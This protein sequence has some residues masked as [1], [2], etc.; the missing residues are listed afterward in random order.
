MKRLLIYFF[1]DK[2]G[3]V[4]DYIPYFLRAAQGLCQEVC[5]VVNGLLSDEGRAKV[6]PLTTKILI[7]ENKGLDAAAY[8]AAIFEYGFEKLA[9]YDEVICT[10][11]TFFGPFYPLEEMFGAMR[12]RKC[13][14]WTM[15]KWP[16]RYNFPFSFTYSHLP[17]GFCVY[18]NSLVSS[19]HF[20]RYW[21]SLSE[22]N[23]YND[24]VMF[25]EQRQTPYYEKLGFIGA[26]YI[27]GTPYQL[28]KVTHFPLELADRLLAEAKAPLLKR[29]VFFSDGTGGF[30]YSRA[31]KAI[32]QWIPENSSYPISLV[33]KNMGRTDDKYQT[34]CQ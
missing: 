15:Y 33:H 25:H 22:T 27:D 30:P 2:A 26:A 21:E 24:S 31:A 20:R 7:R 6:E 14:W 4:D 34:L 28:P 18:R 29:R 13:D 16:I 5:F 12:T 32:L 3:I 11:F 17:S 23:S 9:E 19:V 10:N 8:Q 1:Y